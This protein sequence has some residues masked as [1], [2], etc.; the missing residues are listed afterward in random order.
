MKSVAVVLSGCGVFD[1]SEIHEAVCTLLALDKLGISYQC[2]APNITQTQVVNHLTHQPMQEER[3]VLVESARIARGDTLDISK[4]N[5]DD[6]DAAIYPGG[7]GAVLNNSSFA[8]QGVN[9]EIQPDVLAFAKGM[10]TA[11]KPQG[12]LCIS[13]VLISQIYGEGVQ[14][15][16]GNDQPTTDAVTAM[17]GIH[18]ETSVSEIVI[19][20]K[21]RVVSTAAY[22]LANGITEVAEAVDKLVNALLAF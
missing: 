13:P 3:N 19:D 4:A 1:G 5:V 2:L 9:F 20:Q 12:F 6:Y 21:H 15:T 16:I 14:L 8:L 18:I 22:M 10:A 11:K 17:G 7:F